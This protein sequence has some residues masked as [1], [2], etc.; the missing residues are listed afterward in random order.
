[1][2]FL[3]T[4]AISVVNNEIA[5][6][7]QARTCEQQ[8]AVARTRHQAKAE[9]SQ[10]LGEA[11]HYLDWALMARLNRW[12]RLNSWLTSGVATGINCDHSQSDHNDERRWLS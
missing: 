7:R 9:A 12:L 5:A 10:R 4:V 2:G 1:M 8:E 11:A 3:R 6:R